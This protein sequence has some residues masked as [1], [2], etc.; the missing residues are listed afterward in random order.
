VP[1]ALVL[2]E[3]D[4]WLAPRFHGGAIRDA[5]RT[6]EVIADMP[7]AGHGSMLSS[8]P[9][10]IDGIAGELLNDPL[11]FTRDNMGEVDRKIAAFFTRH[12]PPISGTRAANALAPAAAD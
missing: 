7:A 2:A 6:C 8:L 12:I 10:G 9:P 1:L 11:G 5:C 3:K 4:R